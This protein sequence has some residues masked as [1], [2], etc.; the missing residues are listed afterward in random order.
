MKYKLFICFFLVSVI[1]G[2]EEKSSEI[3]CSTSQ[4]NTQF[5]AY[6]IM[7]SFAIEVSGER[8]HIL[9]ADALVNKVSKLYQEFLCDIAPGDFLCFEWRESFKNAFLSKDKKRFFISELGALAAIFQRNKNK[10]LQAKDVEN[11]EREV[12]GDINCLYDEYSKSH[13]FTS[14]QL[15]NVSHYFE[16]LCKYDTERYQILGE[17]MYTYAE[18]SLQAWYRLKEM[19]MYKIEIDFI[20]KVDEIRELFQKY[21]LS[22]VDEGRPEKKIL[23]SRHLMS[24][25][26]KAKKRFVICEK[27]KVFFN[28]SSCLYAERYL[29]QSAD[30]ESQAS[31]LGLPKQEIINSQKWHNALKELTSIEETLKKSKYYVDSPISRLSLSLNDLAS[32]EEMLKK[33]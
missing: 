13:N 29:E 9:G 4:L 6:K 31:M 21:Y 33:V 19:F 15:Q 11:K 3:F 2:L 8:V 22:D 26:N 32:I 14:S 27:E 10:T 17:H 28:Q 7:F 25:V 24:S 12:V 18:E 1:Y 30:R 20:H 23:L 5:L 16:E